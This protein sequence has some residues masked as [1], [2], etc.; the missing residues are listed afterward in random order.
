MA[1][2]SISDFKFGLDRRRPRVAGVPGTLWNIKNAHL[3]RGGDIERAKKFVPLY[4]LPVGTHGMGQ[5]GGQ[6]YVFGSADLATSM[7]VG[8]QYQRLQSPNGQAMSSV[9]NVRTFDRRLYVVAE[10]A[11]GNIYHFYDGSRVTALDGLSDSNSNLA[12]VAAYLADRINTRSD[13]VATAFGNSV[14]VRAITP[15][16]AF[17]FTGST[18]DGGGNNDQTII[19]STVQA[20]VSAV[21][22]TQASGT[23]TITGGTFDP[24]VNSLTQVTVNAVNLLAGPVNWVTSNAATATRLAQ[25]INNRTNISGY[26]ATASGDVVTIKAAPGTGATS[27]GFVVNATTAGNVTFSKTNMAGGVAAVSP[28]AQVSL[29]VLSG[30]FQ[31]LDVFTITVNGTDYKATGRAAGS[32][33]SAFTFKRR[34]WLTANSLLRYCKINTPTDWTDT[35]VASGAGFINASNESEGAERLTVNAEYSGR[36]AVFSPS[37]V[38]IYDISTDAQANALI[39][40]LENTGT[41]AGRSVIAYGNNDVFYL[42]TTGIRSLRARDSSNA[43]FVSDIGTAV[44]PFVRAWVESQPEETVRRAVG[45]VEPIDGRFWLAIG[46]RIFV[47]S[48]FPGSK[49]SAWS[50]YEPGFTVT[51]FARIRDQV[52]TRAGNTIYLYG[53]LTG[54]EYPAFNEQVVEVETPFMSAQTPATI[55]MLTGFDMACENTW[56]VDLMVDPNDATKFVNVG[57]ITKTTY[58]GPHINVPARSSMVAIKLQCDRPGYATISNMAI[59]FESEEAR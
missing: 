20:N 9:L 58:S 2:L 13:V 15:G 12:A 19:V 34:V 10:Y 47:L 50:Y 55:K 28:V 14:T 42:D 35:N 32:G 57:K 29:A 59:H 30:T 40:T 45:V 48:Y 53:G 51:D 25:E 8:V 56:D 31:P 37:S 1:Y 6:L 22:E 23:V 46:S 18:T 33:T 54:Q 39:Q 21:A 52:F 27:N 38:R 4:N 3:T 41:I 11:D 7:P 36:M 24:G 26:S 49:I 16:T 5:V 17:T 44:D 43:A